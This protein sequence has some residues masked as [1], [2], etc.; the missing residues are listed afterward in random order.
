ME[1][2]VGGWTLSGILNAHS[3][4]PYTPQYGFGE[5][6]GGFY[7]V[8]NFGKNAG[9]GDA[10]AGSA[11]IL[12]AA[13][14][15]GFKPNFRSNSS[16]D[17]T[18][19]FTAPTVVPGTLFDCLFPNPDPTKCPSGQQ[20]Y[21]PLPTFPGMARNTFRGPSY[22]DVD[23]TLSKAFVLPSNKILG[24]HAG[25]EF[26]ANFFNLF[27]KLNLYNPQV[28]IMNSHFAEAQN[29][30]GARVIEMQARFSF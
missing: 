15:G 9:G 12:P 11:N 22:F 8:F 27:N 10:D 24:E 19:F 29:V 13:Y 6:D 5:L 26:R 3:G 30:L 1:K 28:D 21:G 7:P 20:G 2:I 17:A 23:A 14:K 16:L 18:S 4:F 25:L